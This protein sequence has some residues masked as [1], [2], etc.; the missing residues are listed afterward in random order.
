MKKKDILATNMIANRLGTSAG[1]ITKIDKSLRKIMME[2]AT[3]R[4]G[5]ANDFAYRSYLHVARNF[6]LS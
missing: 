4:R 6:A 3:V 5:F 1:E 2:A